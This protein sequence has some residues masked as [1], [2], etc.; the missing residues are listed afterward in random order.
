MK[1]GMRPKIE[2]DAA[3]PE[4]KKPV[5]RSQ[6]V[7]ETKKKG[8]KIVTDLREIIEAMIKENNFLKVNG[9]L[10]MQVIDS[11]PGK[12]S[13]IT[14]SVIRNHF[15]S[16]DNLIKILNFPTTKKGARLIVKRFL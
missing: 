15:V 13:G 12:F 10:I 6:Q 7:E 11:N 14:Y 9:M 3:K 1:E 4:K 2:S 5:P 8:E 16:M